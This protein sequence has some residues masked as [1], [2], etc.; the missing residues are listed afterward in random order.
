[1]SLTLCV[2]AAMVKDEQGRP[3]IVVREY[4]SSEQSID[5]LEQILTG[6]VSTARGKRRDSMVPMP[7]SHILLL[8]RQWQALSRHLWCDLF[9]R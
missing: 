5:P 4:V 7:S 9:F 2:I 1:M 3:F 8:P 6:Y